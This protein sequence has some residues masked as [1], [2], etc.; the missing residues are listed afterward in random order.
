MKSMKVRGIG[1]LAL[2]LMAVAAPALAQDKAAEVLAASRQAIGGDKV[3]NLKSFSVKSRMARNIG[4]RQMTSELEILAETPDKYVRIEDITAPVARTMTTGFSGDKAI[5]P[6]GMMGGPGGM[7]I[8]MGGPGGPVAGPDV[9]P[10]PEQ[11]AQMNE[12]MLRGQRTEISRLMLGWF[13]AAHPSLGATYTYAGEAESP[14]GKA[15]VIDVKAGE[16]E[17]KLFIDQATNLPL[18]LTYRGPE[19]RTMVMS[20][21]G[22]PAGAAGGR[23]GGAAGHAGPGAP[24]AATTQAAVDARL[25]AMRNEPP[26]MADFQIYFSDW[27]EADGVRF[28][29]VLQRAMGGNTVEE[30]EITKVAVNPKIDPKKFQ[31]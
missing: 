15:H 19:P 9:K 18:M 16:F 30:W 31:Q 8:V 23:Q 25:E 14:D 13:A 20:G 7:R 22:G 4:D 1:A 24:T 5:R 11:E 10:T 29:H 17:A 2:G 27:R 21:P 28:P 12:M 26:K 6:A 3:A